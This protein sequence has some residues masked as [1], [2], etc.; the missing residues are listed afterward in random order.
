MKKIDRYILRQ[1]VQT[2]AFAL[3]A[4]IVIF[5]AVDMMENL[6]DFLDRHATA[7]IIAL[8]YLHF[9]PEIVKLMVPVAM[10]L[11]ALFTTGRSSTYNELTALKSGGVSLYR[12]MLP[13][14]VFALVLSAAM[15]YF[16]G[17]VVPSSNRQKFQ[18]ARTYFQKNIEFVSRNNI[19]IQVSPMRI[20][21][22]GLF[23]DQRNLATQV[24]IQDFDPVHP[25]V[26]AHRYDAKQMQWDEKTETWTLGQGIERQFAGEKEIARQFVTQ[27][28]GH[29]NFSP[30]DIRKKQQRPEEMNFTELGEFIANQ[31]RAGQDVSRWLVDYYGKISFPFASTVVVLFGIPFASVRRRSGPGIEFGIAIAITFLYMVFL[32]VSQAFGYNGD[33]NPLLTAW[34]ANLLFLIAALYNVLRVAK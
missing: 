10:L 24:S 4:F 14:V 29:L 13:V 22:I 5:V 33:L 8:Y 31:Q 11:S 17:W 2:A 32:Q 30:E 3:L 7:P 9:I 28:I 23:D 6:D 1:F 27:P 34:L 18:I 20:L 26:I 16:N 12:F 25:T 15:I 19:F 21:V